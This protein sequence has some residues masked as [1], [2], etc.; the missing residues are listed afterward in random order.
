[1]YCPKC[2]KNVMIR[3]HSAI[4]AVINLIKLPI[5]QIPIITMPI[6]LII[7]I[8]IKNKITMYPNNLYKIINSPFQ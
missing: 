8:S 5:I 2:G 3:I 6:R 4:N 1:M 7:G